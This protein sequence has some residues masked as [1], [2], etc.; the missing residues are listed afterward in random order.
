MDSHNDWKSDISL[1][2]WS[3]NLIGQAVVQSDVA[4]SDFLII[5]YVPVHNSP[6]SANEIALI[7]CIRFQRS[8]TDSLFI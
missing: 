5:H 8:I 3:V 2:G 4:V 6:R 1:L 7:G